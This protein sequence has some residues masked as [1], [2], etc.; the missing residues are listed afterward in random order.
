[1]VARTRLNVRLH[2]RMST[3][4]ALNYA[5]YRRFRKGT[6]YSSV[7]F[8]PTVMNFEDLNNDIKYQLNEWRSSQAHSLIRVEHKK[9]STYTK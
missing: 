3:L 6:N 7:L 1:M 8:G 4:R 9:G 5:D 2:V